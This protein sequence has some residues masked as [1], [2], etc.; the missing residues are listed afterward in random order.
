MEG[1]VVFPF[2]RFAGIFISFFKF[3]GDEKEVTILETE[4]PRDI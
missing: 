4:K 3:Q 1:K 2:E